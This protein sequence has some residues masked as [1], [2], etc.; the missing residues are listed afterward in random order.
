[1]SEVYRREIVQHIVRNL[2]DVQ[3]LRIIAAEPTW[4]YRIKKQVESDFGLKLRHGALYPALNALEAKGLVIC[5]RQQKDG[6]ARKVYATTEQG[7]AYLAAY[8]AVLQ[9]QLD[10]E[11]QKI[12]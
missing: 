6:R 9:G 12:T 8:Y 1:M 10:G 4:G 2:L 7:R 5:R 11:D 3:L